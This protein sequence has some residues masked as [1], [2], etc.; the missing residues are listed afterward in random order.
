[1]QIY[2]CISF[3]FKESFHPNNSKTLWQSNYHH[4][5]LS[6]LELRSLHCRWLQR[7]KWCLFDSLHTQFTARS[8]FLTSSDISFHKAVYSQGSN[9]KKAWAGASKEGPSTDRPPQVFTPPQP[10]HAQVSPLLLRPQLLPPVFIHQS[11]TFILLSKMSAILNSCPVSQSPSPWLVLPSF[12]ALC[13]PKGW[14][15]IT[16]C[17]R[18]PPRVQSACQPTSHSAADKPSLLDQIYHCQMY[19]QSL[20]L[21]NTLHIY[22]PSV[23]RN[24]YS[25]STNSISASCLISLFTQGPGPS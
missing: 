2:T 4:Q 10:P 25:S 7:P 15:L 14:Q 9:T 6:V 20:C 24:I 1:M 5:R 11:L 21:P 22:C 16:S 17:P 8:G 19:F 18:L 13:H 3:I 23:Q 12:P